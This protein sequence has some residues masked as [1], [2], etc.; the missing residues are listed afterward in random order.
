MIQHNNVKFARQVALPLLGIMST[1]EV[2]INYLNGTNYM[3]SRP[4]YQL[5]TISLSL[6]YTLFIISLFHHNLFL[7]YPL[8]IISPFHYI[9]FSSYHIF[10]ISP[11]DQF[12]GGLIMAIA[13]EHCGLHNRVALRIIM[14]VTTNKTRHLGGKRAYLSY[15]YQPW[16][17]QCKYPCH[18]YCGAES[19]SLA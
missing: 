17:W 6:S 19:R 18:A 8:F 14:L 4:P 12:L 1:K 15:A 13:V 7:Q 10:T 11:F 16:P 9:L 5:F 2:A 3:V